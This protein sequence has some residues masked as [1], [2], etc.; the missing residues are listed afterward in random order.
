MEF[1]KNQQWR[2][3][4]KQFDTTKK[5]STENI[6]LLK[7][8]IQLSVSSF[9]L[10][11][12]KVLIIENLELKEQLKKVSWNQSQI[13]DCSHLFVFCN[14]E[15]TKN[16]HI[17]EFIELTSSVRKIDLENIR[18]YGDFIKESL[19]NKSFK[20]KFEW[21]KNQTYIAMANLLSA[22]AELQIDACPMEGFEAEKYNEILGLNKLELNASVIVTVGYRD[23]KDKTQF[24]KKV[25]KSIES[26]FIE[27]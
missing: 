25:R 27:M 4:T 15:N 13:T 17:D 2:Y 26:L 7:K 1:I 20:E 3:A 10:Q 16:E 14:Y 18:G 23:E 6:E 19:A 9:G 5:V 12:Y 22:C 11:L 8:S 21:T 24:D